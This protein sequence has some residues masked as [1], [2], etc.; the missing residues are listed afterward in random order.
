MPRKWVVLSAVLAVTALSAT[1]WA[2]GATGV[3]GAARAT[4]K[5]DSPDEAFLPGDT[6]PDAPELAA[7]GPYGV[8]V[9]TLHVTNPN[10]VDILRYS[11]TNTNPRYDRPLTLE[12]WYPADIKGK[13]KDELA[14]YSDVL[15]SGPN[16][17][18]R[19]NVPF[20]FQGRALRDAKPDASGAGYPLIIV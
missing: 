6:R 12:V 14:T 4:L 16:D 2:L 20:E 8:G 5:G 18:A 3:T 13:K 11:A 7:R 10:Q 17:P 19:P 9:R 1:T 15:G